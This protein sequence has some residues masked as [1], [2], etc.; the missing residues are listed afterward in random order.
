MIS[1]IRFKSRW[2][3]VC[4]VITLPPDTIAAL[5]ITFLSLLIPFQAQAGTD[6][7]MTVGAID[8]STTQVPEAVIKEAYRRLEIPLTVIKLPPARSLKMTSSGLYDAELARVKVDPKLYPDLIRVPVAIDLIEAAVFSKSVDFSVDGWDSLKPYRIGIRRGVKFTQRGTQGMN[9]VIAN[10]NEQLF[11][12]LDKDR[13]DI[14][15]LN[16]HNALTAIE[17]LGLTNIRMLKPSV[18][19]LEVFHYL[20][21]KNKHLL[22]ALTHELQ[23]MEQSGEIEAIMSRVRATTPPR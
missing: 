18:H 12:M 3:A 13:V 17:R 14:V 9:V 2:C 1:G 21:K 6:N 19:Y 7:G 20:H 8:S 15:V 16:K 10:E 11:K 4:S 5:T 23:Q 22:P